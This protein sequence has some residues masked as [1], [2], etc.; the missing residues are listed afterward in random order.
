MEVQTDFNTERDLIIKH[1]DKH[2]SQICTKLNTLLEQ[3]EIEIKDVHKVLFL[4]LIY[5]VFK[6]TINNLTKYY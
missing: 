4:Y 1:F 6:F 5:L 2:L 3:K